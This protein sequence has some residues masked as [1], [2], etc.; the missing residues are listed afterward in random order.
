M[1][2]VLS[3]ESFN[4]SFKKFIARHPGM[5]KR[6]IEKLRALEADPYAPS[7]RLHKLSGRLEEFYA[8][9][10]DHNNRIV[11]DPDFENDIFYLVDIGDHD[12]VY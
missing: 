9:S 8:I 3:Y 7:L 2:K 4:R 11:I 12:A 5:R 1:P 6:I 10:I